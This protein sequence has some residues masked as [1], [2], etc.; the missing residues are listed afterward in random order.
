MTPFFSKEQFEETTPQHVQH[1]HY[2]VFHHLPTSFAENQFYYTHYS[3]DLSNYIHPN[4]S[5][6]SLSYRLPSGSQIIASLFVMAG[7]VYDS[8]EAGDSVVPPSH[9]HAHTSKRRSLPPLLLP[10]GSRTPSNQTRT[11]TPRNSRTRDTP[12]PPPPSD[13]IRQPHLHHHHPPPP[14]PPSRPS[15]CPNPPPH[16]TPTPR[17]PRSSRRTPSS[18][19]N[20]TRIP[21]CPPVR[22][23]V[24]TVAACPPVRGRCR[25][26]RRG[27]RTTRRPIPASCRGGGRRAWRGPP[28]RIRGGGVAFRGGLVDDWVVVAVAVAAVV[29]VAAVV[30]SSSAVSARAPP[31]V[32]HRGF[33]RGGATGGSSPA[34]RDG[35]FGTRD[36]DD[37]AAVVVGFAVGPVRGYD[38]DVRRSRRPRFEGDCRVA[39]TPR[40]H[41]RRRRSRHR[42]TSTTTNPLVSRWSPRSTRRDA[43]SRPPPTRRPPPRRPRRYR[44]RRWERRTDEDLPK[45]TRRDSDGG[46]CDDAAI[47]RCTPCTF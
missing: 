33:A 4:V 8:N 25:R 22:T 9:T 15:P 47:F 12:Y 31:S 41:R 28:P 10:H 24:R 27:T 32:S 44:S 6:P 37:D 30:D 2:L 26:R 35:A 36:R 5:K 34:G 42:P 40:S 11:E 38:D 14:S 17:T 13:T 20:P 7:G 23:T 1:I 21:P 16:R 43:E 3:T 45:W 18:S 46:R 39:R 29:V 19:R